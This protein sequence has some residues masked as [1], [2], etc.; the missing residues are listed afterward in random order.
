MASARIGACRRRCCCRARCIRRRRPPSWVAGALPAEAS[1]G[2]FRDSGSLATSGPG[3]HRGD[4][5]RGRERVAG[6]SHP[7]QTGCRRPQFDAVAVPEQ[8]PLRE[9]LRKYA[10]T[11][12]GP[13]GNKQDVGSTSDTAQAALTEMYKVLAREQSS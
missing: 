1:N 3:P 5:G 7:P 9:L 4:V 10:K 2:R 8:T 11:V 13:E 12:E 6:E